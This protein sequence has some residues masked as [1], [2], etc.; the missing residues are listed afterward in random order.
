M[1]SLPA[2][3]AYSYAMV[4]VV[5]RVDRGEFINAGVV[6][7]SP[8]RR[9]LGASTWLDER[10]LVALWP[11][12]DVNLIRRHLHALQQVAEGGSEG[13]PIAALSQRERFHWLTAPRSA[14][15]QISPVRT[16]ISDNPEQML[17]RLT[18]DIVAM[19]DR[20]PATS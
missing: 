12:A 9:Y 14:M 13:G 16:G 18:A 11:N 3:P 1:P 20:A 17:A 10:R 2:K 19:P 5:P 15:I 8:E 6:L 7:Y 4:R